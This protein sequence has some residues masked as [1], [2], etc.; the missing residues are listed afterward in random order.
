MTTFSFLLLCQLRE[1]FSLTGP[2]VKRVM[3]LQVLFH[4]AVIVGTAQGLTFMVSLFTEALS[5]Y[6][7]PANNRNNV[8]SQVHGQCVASTCSKGATTRR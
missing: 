7:G 4:V 1:E 3:F 5:V 6:P 2:L 8:G